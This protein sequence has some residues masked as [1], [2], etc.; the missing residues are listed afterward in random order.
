MTGGVLLIWMNNVDTP[1]GDVTLS[2]SPGDICSTPPS[3]P[4]P[5]PSALTF[6][7]P[8]ISLSTN[9]T[10][11]LHPHLLPCLFLIFDPFIYLVKPR[12]GI[13]Q[14]DPRMHGRLLWTT[15]INVSLQMPRRWRPH[16]PRWS[17]RRWSFRAW[18]YTTRGTWSV[19]SDGRRRWLATF[20]SSSALLWIG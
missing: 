17:T 12:E 1:H 5:L 14:S 2:V 6:R 15:L 19:C 10:H 7:S 8:P 13:I 4:L 9:P 11:R 16:L 20:T 3:P 18:W